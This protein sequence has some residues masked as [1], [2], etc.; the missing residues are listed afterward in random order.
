MESGSRDRKNVSTPIHS[1]VEAVDWVPSVENEYPY[2]KPAALSHYGPGHR[3]LAHNRIK[4]LEKVLQVCV[5]Q[6][7]PKAG[8]IVSILAKDFDLPIAEEERNLL[9]KL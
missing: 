1:L 9:P 6:I 7:D 8:D 2:S 4:D 3:L 5:D